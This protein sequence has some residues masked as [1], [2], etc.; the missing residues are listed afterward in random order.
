MTTARQRILDYLN[1]HPEGADDDELAA[2]LHLSARQQAN[3]ICRELVTE[4]LVRRERVDGKLR[5]F[6]TGQSAPKPEP[7]DTSEHPWY[8]EGHVQARVEQHLR[9][10]G[11]TIVRTANTA[12]HEQGTDI[13]ARK[14]RRPLWVTVK[15]YPRS[16]ERTNATV[17]APHWFKDAVFDL[18][19]WRGESAEADVALALPDFP[20]YRKL[21]AKVAWLQPVIKYR[22]FWVNAGGD[23]RIE[24]GM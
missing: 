14:D 22:V 17:Q 7:V 15:G 12:N 8:W 16:T 9:G 21:L 6:A 20:R 11:Y 2:A 23:V 19:V 24:P 1:H 13:E 18:L 3:T 10:Q 5:N 4:R